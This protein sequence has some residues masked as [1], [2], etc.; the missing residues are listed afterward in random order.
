ML[1]V[2]PLFGSPTIMNNFGYIM[3]E[4]IVQP[5]LLEPQYQI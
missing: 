3:H 4:T 5:K 2:L 1:T